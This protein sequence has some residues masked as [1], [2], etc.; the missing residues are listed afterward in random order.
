MARALR[1]DTEPVD[2]GELDDRDDVL[3][4]LGER[5]RE[6][7]LVDGEVPG[8]PGGVPL[9][10]AR[11]HDLARDPG[12]KGADVGTARRLGVDAQDGHQGLLSIAY[13]GCSPGR[14]AA[15]CGF[16]ASHGAAVHTFRAVGLKTP[17]TS[18]WKGF[19][20]RK[21]FQ[22]WELAVCYGGIHTLV[23]L[24]T[25]NRIIRRI[26]IGFASGICPGLTPKQPLTAADKA[27]ITTVVQKLSKPAKVKA[28]HYKVAID[29]KEWAS[30]LI[31]GKD[32][33]GH[34]IQPG[35]A[36]FHHGTTWTLVDIGTDAVGCEQVPIKPLTQIG[37]D[38]PG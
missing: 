2:A 17:S 25:E 33:Q 16:P 20:F 9:G 27:A 23:N 1:C 38:C 32:P 21:D 35:F 12:A 36:V 26:A 34:P 6:R 18:T 15:P 19:T 28:S 11:K 8:Q 14:P 31:T 7:P 37:G 29:S 24:D 13:R 30:A 10:V 22:S 4:G 5:D 3:G